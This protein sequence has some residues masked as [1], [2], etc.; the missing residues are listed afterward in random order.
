MDELQ[1]YN[2]QVIERR[3]ADFAVGPE[4]SP[5]SSLELVT[6]VLRRWYIVLLFFIV[7]VAAGLP[8]IWLLIKPLYVVTGTIEVAPILQNPLTGEADSGEISNYQ[9]FMFTQ[10]QFVTSDPVLQRVADDLAKTDLDFF[11]KPSID[12]IM[13][14][15][16]KVD[17]RMIS[18]EPT[19][20]L[21]R[22]ISD[23]TIQVRPGDRTQMLDITMN[24]ANEG[25]AKRIVNSF[26]NAYMAYAGSA[27]SQSEDQK[28]NLLENEKKSLLAKIGSQ[29]Q[30]IREL[31]QEYGSTDLG[32]RYDMKLTSRVATLL[33]ELTKAEAQRIALEARLQFFEEMPDQNVPPQEVLSMRNEYINADTAL[34]QLAQQIIQLE[35][36]L[37][38]AK[39]TLAP[40]NPALQQKQSLLDAFKGQLEDKR[41]QVGDDFDEM[42]AQTNANAGRKQLQKVKAELDQTSAYEKRLREV[43]SKEDTQ[44]INIGKKQLDIQE[45]NYQLGLDQQMYDTICR[46][47]QELDLQRKRPARVSIGYMAQLEEIRDKRLKFSA[48]LLFFALAGGAMLAYLTDKADR[49]LWTPQDVAKRIGIRI[50]GTTTSPGSVRK[51]LLSKQVVEDYQVI[52][53]NLGLL[54]GQGIPRKLVVTSPG[55]GEGKTTFAINL[56]TSIAKSGKKVLL[57]DGD[58][59]KPDIAN[60][61]G[62]PKGSRGLQDL[63]FGKD[64]GQA[65]ITM[66]TMGLDVLAADSRNRADAYELLALPATS[67]RIDTISEN[68]DQVI[69]DTPPVLALP[70]ALIWAKMADA[71][72][73][74]SFSGQTSG[75]D[76]KEAKE[77]LTAI[78]IRILGTVLVNVPISH[79]Y[80]R[81]GY[82][83]YSGDAHKRDRR[84]TDSRLLLPTSSPEE[85]QEKA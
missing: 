23:R 52:R 11:K 78:N 33:A 69:I 4:V 2:D 60:L 22:A 70:D 77:K 43:L 18:T 29:R 26:I 19:S 62:L 41:K 68:Y 76:L 14:L 35:Q 66:A 45:A 27:S 30:R 84:H 85:K 48:A 37:I 72:I 50:I 57:I 63:L 15:K 74:T 51:S 36:E 42:I 49:R 25:E 80:Y 6:G 55:M 46:R 73:L 39:Q 83:Y 3:P 71:V 65:V 59:R 13:R 7:I 58:L 81:Y 31:G 61:L 34:K 16:Q 12:P 53:A 21:R 8:A 20:L 9:S 54:N 82:S 1:K 44:T 67:R 47:I 38:V 32:G 24:S 10:A 79:A 28:L 40:Q 75:D 64:A 56:A 5:G 17:N